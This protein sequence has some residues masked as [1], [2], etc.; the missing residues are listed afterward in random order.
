MADFYVLPAIQP[1]GTLQVVADTAEE[2]LAEGARKGGFTS[3]VLVAIPVEHIVYASIEV[4][5]AP[6][7]VTPIPRPTMPGFEAPAPLPAPEPLPEP[8]P[9]DPPPAP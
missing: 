7:I 5:P 3:G 4:Q 9:L 1:M 2:A 8:A 6:V